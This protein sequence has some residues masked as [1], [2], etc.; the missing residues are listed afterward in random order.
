L[1]EVHPALLP[2]EAEDKGPIRGIMD[3]TWDDLLANQ[4]VAVPY[5]RA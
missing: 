2:P 1:D 5:E 4:P 3:M